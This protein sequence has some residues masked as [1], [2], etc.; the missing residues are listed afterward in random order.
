MS[1]EGNVGA[2]GWYEMTAAVPLDID[3]AA[4]GRHFEDT[5]GDTSYC[6]GCRL[7]LEGIHC[8]HGWGCT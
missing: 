2:R 4:A 7:C 8:A 6:F 3:T 1:A 5:Q